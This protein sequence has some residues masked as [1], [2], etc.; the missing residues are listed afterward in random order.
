[1]NR[2]V[3]KQFIK[4]KY[5]SIAGYNS[6]V[7]N[8]IEKSI[9][10]I[11]QRYDNFI[12]DNPNWYNSVDN[13]NYE[14]YFSFVDDLAY[15]SQTLSDEV[16]QIHRKSIVFHFYSSFEKDLYD[17]SNMVGSESVFKIGDLK[18]NS[19][20]E[21]FKFFLKKVD[22]TLF[23]DIS[24]DLIFFNKI[25][26]LRNFITHHNSIIS[27]NNTHYNNLTEFSKNRFTLKS[28]GKNSDH[29]VYTIV[30]DKKE[31]INEM[32]KKIED[33]IEKVLI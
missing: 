26:I 31:L 5:D 8:N 4:F 33:L 16:L 7:E 9:A 13:I 15:E 20:F 17:L 11:N 1:M 29:E 22:P 3:F 30:L 14:Y 28:I 6:F 19:I 23:N 25:R 10:E 24:Q 32:F 21:Q 12:K 27:S 18:G 2:G